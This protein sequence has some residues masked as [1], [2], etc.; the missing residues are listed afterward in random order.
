LSNEDLLRPT[1]SDYRKPPSLY[2][3][4]GFFLSA[5]F[6]GPLGAGLYALA[7][8]FRL[9]RLPRDAP[10]ITCIVAAAY[11]G[12]IQLHDL[13]ALD[14]LTDYLGG[15]RSGSLGI[16]L[17]G[18]GIACFGAI[19]FLHRGFFRAA[20]VSGMKARQGWLPGI[21]AVL[22]GMAANIAFVTWIQHH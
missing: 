13:G 7:N 8:S 2:N 19:Y 16:M 5:F 14:Q 1:L 3:S 20:R 9:E 10:V 18:F 17:R 21:V 22:A 12:M 11:L 6:G 4:T 15:S